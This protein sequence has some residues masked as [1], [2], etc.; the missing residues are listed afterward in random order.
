METTLIQKAT[1]LDGHSKYN[2]QV[3]D[4]LVQGGIIKEIADNISNKGV[5]HIYKADQQYVSNGW[6]DMQANFCDP[7]FEHKENLFSGLQA[8]GN[9]GFTQVCPT[10]N[11]HPPIS[12]K[13]QIEYLLN[14]SKSFNI[15]LPQILP[16]GTITQNR[17]GKDIAEM[18]DMM[19]AGAKGFSDSKKSMLDSGIL[20]RALMYAKNINA[21]LM[22]HC[23]DAHLSL[24]GLM[25]EG[26]ISTKMGVK[27]MPAIAEEIE[28]QRNISLLAYADGSMHINTISTKGSVDLV[29]QAKQKGLK[30]TCGVA[31]VNLLYT[32]EHVSGFDSFYKVNP[33][34]RNAEHI[35]AL[36][37]GLLDGTIDVI[38][39]DHNPHD[40]ESKDVEFDFA[41]F[42]MSTI[43]TF[44]PMILAAKLGLSPAQLVEK[45]VGNPTAI[46]GLS[47]SKIVE[48]EKANLT[49]F[50]FD[51]EW[52]YSGLNKKSKAVN[53]VMLGKILK[54]KADA[55]AY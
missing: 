11:T 3:K 34:L 39:S 4:I 47:K 51:T 22:L 12:N 54:G 15:K 31:V 53:S 1:I 46:L 43:E 40:I 48:G 17:E 10:P 28:L 44:L 16:I 27:G 55:I 50:S 24:G 2:G 26:A 25:H 14:K 23:N 35:D 49:V 45:L 5:A 36:K 30:I 7:G 37:A 29:R 42:G 41:D 32:D 18:Y 19:Q 52:S 33:P 6:I 38:V 13:T 21:T 20:Y 8:A 9:G